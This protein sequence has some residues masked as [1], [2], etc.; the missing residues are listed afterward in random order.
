MTKT[1]DRVVSSAKPYVERAL[2]DEE[3]RENLRKAY[4]AARGLVEL[5]GKKGPGRVAKGIVDDKHVQKNL[6]TA[7]DELRHAVNR[8]QGRERKR[9]SGKLVL[10]VGAGAAALLNPVTGPR[11]RRWLKDKLSGGN[12]EFGYSGNSGHSEND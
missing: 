10:L 5:A 7:V 2:H 9:R 3:I 1:A 6:Q 12:D 4:Q 8:L 11:T